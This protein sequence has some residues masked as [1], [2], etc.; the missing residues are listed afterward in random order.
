MGFGLIFDSIHYEIGGRKVLQSVDLEIESGKICGLLGPNGSGKTTLLKIGAGLTLPAGGAVSIDGQA[1]PKKKLLQRYRKI[2][3]LS[4]ETFL[5]GDMR[6]SNFLNTSSSEAQAYACRHYPSGL[7]NQTIGSLSNGE[8]RLLELIFIISLNRD[9]LLLDEPFTGIEPLMIEK[10]VKLISKQRD[11]GKGILITD[12]YYRYISEI[13]EL[14]YFIKAGKC[15]QLDADG[16]LGR[17]LRT[18]G[19]LGKAFGQSENR[20]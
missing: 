13:S 7:A 19:Y 6:V 3:Y 11:S 2:A 9:F 5:P 12:Q 20:P 4:Q 1:F 8:L 18:K 17:Q 16:N 10:M 15:Q 14:A